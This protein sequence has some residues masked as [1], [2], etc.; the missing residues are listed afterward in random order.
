M[1]TLR[2]TGKYD[3][4][5]IFQLFRFCLVGGVATI[6]HWC[7]SSFLYKYSGL[8]LSLSIFVGWLFAAFFSFFGHY[9]LTF[10][11]SSKGG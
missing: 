8:S 1:I 7:S 9:Y 10:V 6:I 11:N 5:I 3:R 4:C 2:V